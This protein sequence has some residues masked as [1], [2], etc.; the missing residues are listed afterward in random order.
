LVFGLIFGAIAL[1][2]SSAV[3]KVLAEKGD[4]DKGP[5]VNVCREHDGKWEAKNIKEKDKKDGDF[6]YKGPVHEHGNDKGKPTDAGDNWCKD[7]VPSTT[8]PVC[9][10]RQTCDTVPTTYVYTDKVVTEAGYWGNWELGSASASATVEVRTVQ[11]GNISSDR[12]FTQT[13]CP[14]GYTHTGYNPSWSNVCRTGNQ[15]HYTYAPYQKVY[16][17]CPQGSTIDPDDATK[18][19]TP[20]MVDEHRNWV[21]PI[22]G[23]PADYEVNPEGDNC[24]KVDV[25]EHQGACKTEISNDGG[26]IWTEGTCTPPPPPVDTTPAPEQPRNEPGLSEAKAPSCTDGSTILLPAN[27]HVE[28]S[29]ESATLKWFQTQGDQVNI[30]YKEVGQ[31]GWTHSVGDVTA[32]A[33]AFPDNYNE[34][35]VHGLNPSLGYTFGI[36]QKHGCGGGETVTAVV[37]DGPQSRLFPFS[38]WEWTYDMKHTKKHDSIITAEEYVELIIFSVFVLLP[39]LFISCVVSKIISLFEIIEIEVTEIPESRD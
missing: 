3:S 30:F 39:I 27:F 1:F 28:R 13:T 12:P 24:R 7:N 10:E 14:Q 6:E 11:D 19:L 33:G 21:E 5:K 25:E 32:K 18:C 35:T 2:S 16:G 23:C 20:N 36:M 31:T 37:I 17:A 9:Q 8:P 29:G 34:F 4:E 38:Y 15:G 26:E 22:L